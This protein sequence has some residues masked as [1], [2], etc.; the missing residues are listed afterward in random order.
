MPI[1]ETSGYYMNVEPNNKSSN[2]NMG[3]TRD[4]TYELG[5]SKGRIVGRHQAL[6]E[7][8]KVVEDDS[9]HYWREC[10]ACGYCGGGYLHC[11]HDGIQAPCHKCGVI[12]WTVIGDCECKFVNE[13]PALLQRLEEM[14]K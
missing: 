6:E 9:F 8:K 3:Q 4:K 14:G 11:A 2:H 13:Q 7:V 1:V 12:L 10:N 5:W